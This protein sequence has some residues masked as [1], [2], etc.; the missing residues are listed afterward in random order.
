M[1]ATTATTKHGNLGTGV[2]RDATQ[3]QQR[4]CSGIPV[5]ENRHKLI[6]APSARSMMKAQERRD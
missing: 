5:S 3:R 6:N 4:P 2:S 1:H